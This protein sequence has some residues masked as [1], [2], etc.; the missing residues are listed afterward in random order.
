MVNVAYYKCL[1]CKIASR[2]ARLRSECGN[3]ALCRNHGSP[4]GAFSFPRVTPAPYFMMG[5]MGGEIYR[6]RT[7][8]IMTAKAAPMEPERTE[9]PLAMVLGLAVGTGAPV[10]VADPVPL[11]PEPPPVLPAPPPVPEPPVEPEPVP[12]G[13][14]AL[15]VRVEV[16]R[17]S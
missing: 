11:A 9:A 4:P 12:A 8:A 15:P 13:W 1:G 6:V 3:P 2:L 16:S 14:E 5:E 10:P 7:A 17:D